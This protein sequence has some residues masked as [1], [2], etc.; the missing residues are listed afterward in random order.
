[1][2]NARQSLLRLIQQRRRKAEEELASLREAVSTAE[3]L[4]HD[5][6]AA[7]RVFLS[8]YQPAETV[9]LAGLNEAASG[10]G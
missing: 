9:T 5:V 4:L 3:A 7:E 6:E 2:R 10:S 1:V 8:L